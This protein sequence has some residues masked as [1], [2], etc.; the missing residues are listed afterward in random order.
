MK[1]EQISDLDTYKFLFPKQALAAVYVVSLHLVIERSAVAQI[2]TAVCMQ[3]AAGEG[4]FCHN[5]LKS[6]RDG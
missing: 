2:W 6:C 1:N 4:R 3:T 5:S